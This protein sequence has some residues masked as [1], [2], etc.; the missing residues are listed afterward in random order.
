M[1]EIIILYDQ[2]I[3]INKAVD[4]HEPLMPPPLNA[5]FSQLMHVRMSSASLL[6]YP[7]LCCRA[8]SSINTDEGLV[9]KHYRGI[10]KYI[11]GLSFQ[12]KCYIIYISWD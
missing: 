12:I 10:R 3:L 5:V 2:L 6:I 1:A 9:I 11:Y 7:V 8:L 4:F